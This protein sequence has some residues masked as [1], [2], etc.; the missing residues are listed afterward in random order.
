MSIWSSPSESDSSPLFSKLIFLTGGGGAGI[1]TGTEAR[2]GAGTEARGGAGT[3]ARGV[4]SG[5]GGAEAIK[6][7]YLLLSEPGV[8]LIVCS[9][10][11]VV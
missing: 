5:G 6:A 7:G 2:G 8:S 1:G 9:S 11:L 4:E 3:G 10:K